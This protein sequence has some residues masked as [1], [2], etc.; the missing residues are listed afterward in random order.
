MSRTVPL[1][2]YGHSLAM[3]MVCTR[4][5]L[6]HTHVINTRT[7][8]LHLENTLEGVEFVELNDFSSTADSEK[9]KLQLKTQQEKE[10]PCCFQE[11]G[12]FYH[13]F[14]QKQVMSMSG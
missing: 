12:Q 10:N 6:P 11:H 7:T 3:L 9:R 13:L 14:S 1:S 5:L 8:L 4:E 2:D